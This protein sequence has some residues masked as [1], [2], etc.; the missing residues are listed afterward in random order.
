MFFSVKI[1]LRFYSFLSLA[2]RTGKQKLLR[3]EIAKMKRLMRKKVNS[4]LTE[5]DVETILCIFAGTAD[6]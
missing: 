1:K 6:L 2:S 3:K 5:N 4:H